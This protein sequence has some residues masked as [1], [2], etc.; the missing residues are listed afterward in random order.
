MTEAYLLSAA[1]TTEDDMNSKTQF[2]EALRAGQDFDSLLDLVRSHQMQGLSARVAYD[3]L[4]Q[5]WL[6]FGFNASDEESD[7]RDNLEYV[8]E[9]IWYECPASPD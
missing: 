3:R 4:Q 7:V 6:D 1:R 5:I 2:L 8:M 9:K